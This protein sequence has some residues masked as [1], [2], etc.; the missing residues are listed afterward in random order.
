MEAERELQGMKWEMEKLADCLE[1][2]GD[3]LDSEALAGILRALVSGET[4]QHIIADYA[5]TEAG[6]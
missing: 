4:A 2:L 1:E 6:I 5:L 3:D